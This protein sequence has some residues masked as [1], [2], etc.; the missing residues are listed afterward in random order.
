MTNFRTNKVEFKTFDKVLKERG[1]NLED[2]LVRRDLGEPINL[3]VPTGIRKWDG[4]GGITR[5]VLTVLGGVDGQGKGII[6]EHL[7]TSAA[8]AGFRVAEF[9]F[10]DPEDKVADRWLSTATRIDSRALGLLNITSKDLEPIYASIKAAEPWSKN[11]LFHAGLV[12]VSQVVESLYALDPK[13]DL[14]L[15]DY[16]QAFRAEDESMERTIA[17]FAW[18]ANVFAQ[19]FNCAVVVFSQVVKDVASRGQ[20]AF[21][22]ARKRDPEAWDVSGFCPGPGTQDLAWSAAFGQRGRA[23]GYIFRPGYYERSMGKPEAKDNRIYIRW[24]KVNFGNSGTLEMGFDGPTA[25]I[26]DIEF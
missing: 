23:V 2:L 4:N 21:W 14:V 9:V 16:A 25:R 12:D 3:Y 13:P 20:A 8:R 7:A 24:A 18:D 10:E 5:G 15:V 22:S 17:Q 11:I 1:A 26:F 19:K 6:R